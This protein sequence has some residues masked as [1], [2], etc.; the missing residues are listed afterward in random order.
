MTN[1]YVNNV[2]QETSG[3]VL[4]EKRNLAESSLYFNSSSLPDSG[5][6]DVN[7]YD[8]G[9][10]CE[11]DRNHSQSSDTENNIN[12]NN[13]YNKNDYNRNNNED[14]KVKSNNRTRKLSEKRKNT[15]TAAEPLKAVKTE[16]PNILFMMADDLGNNGLYCFMIIF[17][18]FST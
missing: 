13:D 1:P 2:L 8:N 10:E 12:N 4:S 16:M 15:K 17:G 6:Y 14:E 7:R 9:S 5:S 11:G 3:N 18:V